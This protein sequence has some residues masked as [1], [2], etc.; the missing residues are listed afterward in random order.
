MGVGDDANLLLNWGYIVILLMVKKM[1]TKKK[2]MMLLLMLLMLLMLL[3]GY[4]AIPRAE[5]EGFMQGD[6]TNGGE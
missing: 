2:M 1:M 5:L 6:V 3:L 4:D